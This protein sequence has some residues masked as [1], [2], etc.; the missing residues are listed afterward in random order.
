MGWG[1]SCGGTPPTVKPVGYGMRVRV[2]VETVFS[3]GLEMY[4]TTDILELPSTT[5]DGDQEVWAVHWIERR[6]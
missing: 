6:R 5:S 3:V 2:S 4:R 1:D